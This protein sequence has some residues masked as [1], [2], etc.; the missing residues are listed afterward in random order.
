MKGKIQL[1]KNSTVLC[2]HETCMNYNIITLVLQQFDKDTKKNCS[3]SLLTALTLLILSELVRNIVC[4][5]IGKK[6]G[7]GIGP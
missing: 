1:M 5:S 7:I 4:I 2:L 6:C 3:L